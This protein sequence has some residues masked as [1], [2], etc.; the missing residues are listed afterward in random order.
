M[1]K[2]LVHN[3]LSHLLFR[4]LSLRNDTLEHMLNEKIMSMNVVLM[5]NTNIYKKCFYFI[6]MNLNIALPVK[7]KLVT[8]IPPHSGPSIKKSIRSF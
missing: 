7:M 8:A 6:Y 3:K 1:A 4:I 2:A 5:V